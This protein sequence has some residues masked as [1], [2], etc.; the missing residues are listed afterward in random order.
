[1]VCPMDPKSILIVDDCADTRRIFSTILQFA[2]YRVI[3]GRDGVEAIRLAEAF[4]PAAVIVDLHLPKMDGCAVI[5]SL[6]EKLHTAGIPAILITAD[7]L[8]FARLQAEEAGYHRFLLKPIMPQE[9]LGVVRE[10]LEPEKPFE[11]T[12][13]FEQAAAS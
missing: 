8:G 5:R 10:L 9:L 3:T 11:Q 12:A 4:S 7:A 13:S 2:G 6:R 1:M